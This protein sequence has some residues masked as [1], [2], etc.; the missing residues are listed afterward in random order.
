MANRVDQCRGGAFPGRS[1]PWRQFCGKLQLGDSPLKAFMTHALRLFGPPAVL[2]DGRVESIRLKRCALLLALLVAE[3]LGM[4]RDALTERLWAE[5]D[6]K[7]RRSRLRRLLF[8]I[9]S[10]LGGAAIAE[11]GGRL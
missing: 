9:R 2:R 10:Q 11:Q 1:R 4:D 6:D 8:E 5:G 7:S 3:P